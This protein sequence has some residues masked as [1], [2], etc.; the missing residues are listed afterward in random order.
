MAKACACLCCQCYH[1]RLR[2]I[3]WIRWTRKGKCEGI[4]TVRFT[5]DVL[6]IDSGSMYLQLASVTSCSW[7][8]TPEVSVTVTRL[9]ATTGNWY[10]I[11]LSP[12]LKSSIL[13]SMP[14]GLPSSTSV[15]WKLDLALNEDLLVVLSS[16][17]WNVTNKRKVK[18]A[19][20][21]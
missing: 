15:W 4:V 7:L 19:K 6:V 12:S 10:W 9:E 3:L 11:L 20:Y 2:W 18:W 5:D 13:H 17:A 8:T 1:W 14:Q 21:N 16:F